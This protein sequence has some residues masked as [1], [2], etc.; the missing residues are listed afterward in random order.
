MV[1]N[2]H[3]P[4]P[5]PGLAGQWDKFVGPGATRAEQILSLVPS[6]L[7]A[8]AL[9]FYAYHYQLGWNLGQ[10]IVAAVLAFDVVGGVTT[11]A[12]SSAKR[13]YHR[14]GQG[15]TQHFGFVAIHAIQIFLVAWLFRNF[16]LIY[17]GLVYGYLLISALITLTVPLYI[18]RSVALL[19][20]CGAIVLSRYALWPTP[21]FEWFIPFLFI[22]LL[23]SHLTREEPYMV[24]G[25]NS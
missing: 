19:L 12:T 14:D 3:Y 4:Q 10:Y 21:G 11:N 5:R 13:W 16:D 22:K 24:E 1:S 8:T 25:G 6:I 17:F 23:V 2:W 20:V 9:V 18:Q 7:A 15:F